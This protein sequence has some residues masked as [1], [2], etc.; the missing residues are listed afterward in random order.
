MLMAI[1]IPANAGTTQIGGD[2]V[3]LGPDAECGPDGE[4]SLLTLEL[5]AGSLVGCWFTDEVTYLKVNPSG[6]VQERGRETFRQYDEDGTVVGTFSTTYKFTGKFREDFS[7]IH[8]RC[9]HPIVEGSGTGIYEGI[10]GRVDFKDVDPDAGIL[11]YRGHITFPS[12]G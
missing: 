4:T 8:G 11:E 6:T 5:T 3:V 7:E 1:T 2:G 9:Q 12:G 10:T